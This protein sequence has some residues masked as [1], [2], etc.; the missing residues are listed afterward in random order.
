[1]GLE[2]GEH[3]RR[4]GDAVQA[5][6]G[7][8]QEP[9]EHDRPEDAA[10][11][12]GALLLDG[13]QADQDD[14]G[15]RH[16]GG[17]QRRR[18]DLEAFEGAQ[19]GNRRRDGAVAVEQRGADQADDQ[20][21]G[22]PGAGLGVAGRQQGQQGDDAAFAVVVGAQ[23]EQRVF[24]RDDQDQRPQ[25]E[26][27]DAQHRVGRDRAAVAGGAGRLLQRIERAGADVAIDDAEGAQRGRG[28]E[29]PGAFRHASMNDRHRPSDRQIRA[30]QV[31]NLALR[32]A[33]GS[34]TIRLTI[35]WG[36]VD[37]APWR[38]ATS[39]GC[40]GGVVDAATRFRHPDR[41]RAQ[42]GAVEGPVP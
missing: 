21:P 2:G 16:H 7:D 9:A 34:R 12:G 1:M 13:E 22:A 38:P 20:E 36:R 10:D 29:N 4:A 17:R 32:M 26:R 28:L 31:C 37:P 40:G 3:G 42:R 30:G 41:S 14:D 33:R 18:V 27:D 23:D 11:E 35:A 8:G 5:E 15:E 6:R 25:D 24:D 19:D 39:V